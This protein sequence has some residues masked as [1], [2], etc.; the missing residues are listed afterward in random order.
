MSGHFGEHMTTGITCDIDGYYGTL[1]GLRTDSGYIIGCYVHLW[2][3]AMVSVDLANLIDGKRLITGWHFIDREAFDRT[4]GIN[5]LRE[6]FGWRTGAQPGWFAA[7][8]EKAA[9][10]AGVGS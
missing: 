10:A 1:T 3:G 8:E 7:H 6:Q 9:I 5:D 2:A 4:E